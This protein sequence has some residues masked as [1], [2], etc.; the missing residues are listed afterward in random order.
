MGNRELAIKW[1]ARQQAEQ[2]FRTP[3]GYLKT[4]KF[5]NSEDDKSKFCNLLGKVGHY[6]TW[7]DDRSMADQW[8][9]MI[10]KVADERVEVV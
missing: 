8:Y 7:G 3:Q 2:F 9:K 4:I 1:L 5:D 10:I 6:A